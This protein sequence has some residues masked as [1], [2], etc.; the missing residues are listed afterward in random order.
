MKKRFLVS[1]ISLICIISYSCRVSDKVVFLNVGQGDSSLIYINNEVILID[2]GEFDYTSLNLSKYIPLFTKNIDHLIITHAHK[3]HYGGLNY[4]LKYY[5][6]K[7]VYIPN[8]CKYVGDYNYY[9]QELNRKGSRIYYVSYLYVNSNGIDVLTNGK[10]C[11]DDFKEINNTS[12][13]VITNINNTRILF[14]GDSEK[15]REGELIDLYGEYIKNIDYVKV[16]H[17]CSETS[18]SNEFIHAIS[19]KNVICSFGLDNE[20][21]H[22]SYDVID[23]YLSIKSRILYTY[24]GNIV[25]VP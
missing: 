15:E 13:I 18:S 24:T 2:V 4:L 25:I 12:I 8:D 1:L 21:N 17:H 9:I 19:P 10:V 20:Y 11:E 22:P 16:G 23:R 5:D 6:V 7:N 3:D 14:M